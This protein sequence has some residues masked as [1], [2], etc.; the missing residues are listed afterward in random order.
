MAFWTTLNSDT[1]D[2]KRN[3]RWV[4]HFSGIGE[5]T[6]PTLWYAKK[7]DKPN[8]SISESKHSFLNHTFY[9]PGRVEWQKIT[10]T[11]VD[12]VQPDLAGKINKLILNAGYAPPGTAEGASLA[13]MSKSNFASAIGGNG[14]GGSIGEINILQ[15]GANGIETEFTEKWMLKNAFVTNVKYGSLD[16]ENDDLPEF[17]LELRYDWAECLTN[18][19]EADN[20]GKGWFSK[21]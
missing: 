6:S 9:W 17:E 4:V 20:D 18:G 7:I 10:M 13:T 2:P 15:L 11:L 3:F 16:Y 8:F 5:D 12:P 1:K 19:A 21:R 14:P